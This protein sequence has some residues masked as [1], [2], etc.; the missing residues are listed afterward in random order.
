M[1]LE[2]FRQL[3]TR[4]G[5]LT[6]KPGAFVIVALYAA[7]WLIIDRQSFDFHAVSTLAVWCM[8]L[9]IQRAEHRDAQAMHAKLDELLHTQKSARN[10]L[11][12]IDKKEPEDIERHR[13]EARKND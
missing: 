7:V 13:S 9:L 11:T 5:V 8:T 6:A 4:L 12:L 10:D 3:L 1:N 2:L